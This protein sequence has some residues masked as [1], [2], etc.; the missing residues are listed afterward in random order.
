VV[1][2]ANVVIKNFRAIEDVN[3]ELTRFVNVI[4]GPNA[5]GKTTI[6]QAIRL[7]KA[8][9][10]PRS[11][12]EAQQT[13]ISLGAA[14]PHFPQRVFL[15]SL[16]RDINKPIEVRCTLKLENGEVANVIGGQAE[17][18]NRLLQ[19]QMGQSF[20][21]PASMI[22]FLASEPGKSALAAVKSQ[23]ASQL[24]RL[25]SERTLLL[26]IVLDPQTN[27][28]SAVDQ[29]S[30]PFFS[31]LEQL[32]PPQLAIFSY[33]PADRALPTGEVPVQLGGPDMQQQVEAH[34]SQPQLKYHRLKNMIIGDI[35]L[36]QGS[37]ESLMSE[38]SRIFEGILR[39]RKISSTGVNELGL[40]S[41][42][43][44]DQVGGTQYD[45]DNLS[46]G[47]KNLALTL[48]LIARSIS[49]DGIALFD[50]PELHLNPAVCKDVLGFML[51]SYA[52]PKG[53]QFIISTHSPEILSGAFKDADCALLHIVSS[54]NIA[55]VGHKAYDE[56]SEVLA[57]LGS[58]VSEGLLFEGTL[59][60]EGDDDVAFLENAFPELLKRFKVK[61]RGG[62]REVEKT[63]RRLQELEAS[64]Q[65]V[66][67]IFLLF[68][69]DDEITGLESSSSVR[70]MQWER[71]CLENYLI[72]LSVLTELLK[73]N[74]IARKPFP[75]E[76]E[77]AKVFRDL[78]L[79]QLDGIVAKEQYSRRNYKS[80]ALR[81]EDIEKSDSL[82]GIAEALYSRAETARA[83]IELNSRTAW[84]KDFLDSCATRRAELE[85]VWEASWKERCDGKR[86]FRD[87]QKA[88]HLKI[89]LSAFKS[90]IV[91]RMR[92]TSS[93]NWR[94]V[95]SHLRKLIHGSRPS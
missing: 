32:L 90:Q 27:T 61:D 52:K 9:L 25:Q 37:R 71:R 91:G 78:A 69:R 30:G 68:D 93:D 16:A 57:N 40:L 11:P 67:P 82:S 42:K 4:V 35:V 75:N 59:F 73:K 94:I 20:L 66:D 63:A 84:V 15:R 54:T 76:G 64:G 33:F 12:S 65:R 85:V 50:E 45:I 79:S 34:N 10:A 88:G 5:V 56:Y 62:R 87:F 36:N 3:F 43:I 17:I 89:P 29:F 60:V 18:A 72:D 46:S 21:N 55:R 70:I 51:N 92:D 6:L 2:I 83:S 38:F 39:G 77:V 7:S 58:S 31:Y 14:S 13:L 44:E 86:L 81:S 41:V 1:H 23:L 47:E 80:P 49:D 26:G 53:L 74:D 28:I 48:L 24:E 22:Q 95:D 19:A 8:L